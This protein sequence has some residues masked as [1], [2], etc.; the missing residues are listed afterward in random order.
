MSSKGSQGKYNHVHLIALLTA[1]LSRYHDGF[2]VAVVDELL[3]EVRVGLELNDYAMQQR[4]LAHMRFLG[5]FITMSTLFHQLY[6][7]HLTLLLHLVMEHL[8][9]IYWIPRKTF[10]GSG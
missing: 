1:H 7:G 6:L 9:K 10:S 4:R 2:A 5:A 8:S 3:E